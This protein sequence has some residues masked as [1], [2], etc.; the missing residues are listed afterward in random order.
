MRRN[1]SLRNVPG[2]VNKVYTNDAVCIKVCKTSYEKKADDATAAIETVTFNS[3]AKSAS[4][5]HRLE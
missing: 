5:M 1:N 2:T 4:R 3:F